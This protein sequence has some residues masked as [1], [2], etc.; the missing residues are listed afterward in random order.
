MKNTELLYRRIRF[1]V[2][3]FIIGLIISGV[4]A[5]PLEWELQLLTKVFGIANLQPQDTSGFGRWLLI[6]GDA[7]QHT[8][9]TYPFIAYGFD[10]LAFGHIVIAV[11]FIGAFRDPVK[12]IWLFD[13]GMIACVLVIP[14]ALIFGPV[15]GIPFGWRLIDCSFG[16]F[17]FMPLWLARKWTQQLACKQS[18]ACA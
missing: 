14:W 6:V 12:N 15:R 5:I 18:S 8:N 11:A 3:A 13:F 9:A 10:W 2:M 4:T 7:L 17:G 16:V 1:A